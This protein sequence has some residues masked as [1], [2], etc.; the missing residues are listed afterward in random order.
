MLLRFA[1]L[2]HH[3]LLLLLLDL[4]V[5]VEGLNVRH[6]ALVRVRN[7]LRLALDALLECLKDVGLHVIRMELRFALLVLLELRAHVLS[8]LLLLQLHLVHD[9]VVVLLLTQ[10]L[11]L[12][13]RHPLAQRSQLL[14]TW[15]QFSF[16][17]FHFLLDLLDERCQ[18]LK[19]LA[20]VIVHLLLQLR[21]ALNLIFDCR[22]AGDALLLFEL[23]EE[24]LDVTG[25]T[26]QDIAR[27]LQNLDFSLELLQ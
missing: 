18:L 6:E 2:A 15:R 20:L 25:A 10:V 24:F 19:R 11:L 27:T 23:F 16:F 1:Q 21:H 13:V 17:L 14:D 12:H 8:D 7:V 4:E 5:L 22:V 3:L 9:L 26:L